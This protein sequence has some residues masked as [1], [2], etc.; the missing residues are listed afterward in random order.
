MKSWIV[1]IVAV[2]VGFAGGLGGAFFYSNYL[3]GSNNT[4]IHNY[5][6][7]QLYKSPYLTTEMISNVFGGSWYFNSTEPFSYTSFK[8]PDVINAT[9]ISFRSN[10]RLVNETV[11]NFTA[12]SYANDSFVSFS[13]LM[14]IFS[15]FNS[16]VSNSS[17]QYGLIGEIPTLYFNYSSNQTVI[18]P[19]ANHLIK[20]TFKNVDSEFKIIEEFASNLITYVES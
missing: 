3:S 9:S 1:I 18:F 7:H 4:T 16:S 11:I 13:I 5:S 2:I 20:I 15:A 8:F 17:I 14:E 10:N 12:P 6:P 19:L